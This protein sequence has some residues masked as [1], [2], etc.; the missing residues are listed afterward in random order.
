MTVAY[1]RLK[2]LAQIKASNVDKKSVDGDVLVRLCNYV[3]VYKNDTITDELQFMSATAT[4]GQVAE[5]RLRSGDVIVTKDSESADD[6]GVPAYVPES[7]DDVLCGYHLSLI[8]SDRSQ[9]EPAYLRWVL[10]SSP[11]RHYFTGAA[12]GVTRFALG[13]AELGDTPIPVPGLREQRAIV[14]FLDQETTRIDASVQ[15]KTRILRLT[16]EAKQSFLGELFQRVD[17]AL[18][19]QPLRRL[20]TLIEQGVSPVCENR[21]RAEGEWGVLKL[22]AVAQGVFDSTENKALPMDLRP[23]ERYEIRHGDLLITRA[24]TPRLVGDVCVAHDPP[25]RLL[26]SDLIYR[27]WLTPELS[28]DWVCLFLQS[29]RGRSF[30]SATARGSSRSMVKI[31][32]SD[33]RDVLIPVTSPKVQARCLK[34]LA[35]FNLRTEQLRLVLADQLEKLQECRAAL[36]TAAVAG[37]IDLSEAA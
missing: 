22:S 17:H 34:E 31:R 32:A 1:R 2:H 23:S 18:T 8:R 3:D 27:V 6:I 4:K 14:R 7:M 24:N 25:G 26:I 12:N 15:R 35:D 13:Y 37:Q 36:I 30:F 20:L 9:I 33:I 5:F 16:H 21:P 28:P 11:V 19:W 29:P 10:Q